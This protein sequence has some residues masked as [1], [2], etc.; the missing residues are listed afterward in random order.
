MSE[1]KFERMPL[2]KKLFGSLNDEEKIRAIL[3]AADKPVSKGLLLEFADVEETND[4]KQM[5]ESILQGEEVVTSTNEEGK[6]KYQLH[7]DASYKLFET[8]D[9]TS[10][11]AKIADNLWEDLVHN[12]PEQ[13]E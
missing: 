4:N 10:V 8:I 7:P 13:G 3:A 5:V 2:P 11:L 9:E 6:T 12:D 1:G